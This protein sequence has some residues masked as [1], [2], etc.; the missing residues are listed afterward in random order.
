MFAKFVLPVLVVAA[1]PAASLASS[2]PDWQSFLAQ[3]QL[4]MRHMVNSMSETRSARAISVNYTLCFNWYGS[5]QSNIFKTYNVEYDNCEYEATQSKLTLSEQNAKERDDLVNRGQSMCDTLSACEQIDD[6]LKFYSCYNNASSNNTQE[7]FEIS[8]ASESVL[9]V[10]NIEYQRVE[11]DLTNCTAVARVAYISNLSAS[12]NNL[13]KC[14]QGNWVPT[15][16]ESST[17]APSTTT[18]EAAETTVDPVTEN[19]PE[20][21]VYRRKRNIMGRQ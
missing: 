15:T 7:L 16:E 10:L 3:Q 1:C 6:G 8:A 11:N 20:E 4:V 17:G 2:P 21:D 9:R 5:D 14:L 18:T 19:F 13:E 12:A